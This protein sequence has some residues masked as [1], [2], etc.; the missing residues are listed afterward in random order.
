[1]SCGVEVKD[2][3]IH[4]AATIEMQIM[5]KRETPQAMKISYLN[6]NDDKYANVSIS[7]ELMVSLSLLRLYRYYNRSFTI[8]RWKDDALVFISGFHTSPH[9]HRLC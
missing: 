3:Y 7:C 6:Q 8:M 2:V 9:F 5:F 4:S 1:M